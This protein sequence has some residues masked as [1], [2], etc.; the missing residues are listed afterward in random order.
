MVT[1][2]SSCNASIDVTLPPTITAGQPVTAT[3]TDPGGNTSEF[4]QRL[5]LSSNPKSGP[6]AGGTVLTLSGFDF[7]PGA[8]VNV[9]GLPATGVVVNSY[10]QITA[11]TPG[12]PGGRLNDITVTNLDGTTGTLRNGFVSDFFD[13]SGGG[14]YPFVTQL[15]ANEITAGCGSG[16]YCPND[17]V[18]RAQMA[19]FLLRGHFGLCFVPP[20]ATGTVFTDVPAGSFAAAWIEYLA[21]A[22]VTA[23]CGGG[24]YCPTS[25][26]TRAQMAV[27]LLKTLNGASYL[28][29]ACTTPAFTDVPCSSPFAPWIDELVT[30]G[31]TAGCGGGLY[32]PTTSNT[33]AQMAVFISKTFNL[34]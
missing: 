34:P 2:D 3:A 24:N 5:V 14:F 33:R 30:L 25:P 18:T 11:N 23:G 1:T 6:A 13:V 20:P 7:L 10:T 21:A 22:G 8:A 9:G 19:V 26:V 12:L 32:C 29:P 16:N 28:P 27:F 17:S 15:V 4:S 31:V